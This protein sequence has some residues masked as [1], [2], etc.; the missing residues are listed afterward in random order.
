MRSFDSGI[1]VDED[2]CSVKSSDCSANEYPLRCHLA[3]YEG[4]TYVVAETLSHDLERFHR[5][6]RQQASAGGGA[7]AATT[8]SA[9]YKCGFCI[10]ECS[11]RQELNKHLQIHLGELLAHSFASIYKNECIHFNNDCFC[12]C[13]LFCFVFYLQTGPPQ[14]SCRKCN[15]VG[16]FK[17]LL[18]QHMRNVHHCV[19]EGQEGRKHFLVT[20]YK[21]EARNRHK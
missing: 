17:F 14:H 3:K 18:A 8:P 15:F 12:I 16:H 5:S 6:G 9:T 7:A 11:V 4:Y 21:A 2:L 20:A 1:E 19:L 13:F 10:F